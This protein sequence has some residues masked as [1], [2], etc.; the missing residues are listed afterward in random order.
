MLVATAAKVL[1]WPAVPVEI[2]MHVLRQ[3]AADHL[4]TSSQSFFMVAGSAD[5]VVTSL[6]PPSGIA[7]IA[8]TFR[9]ARSAPRIALVTSDSLILARPRGR[10]FSSDTVVSLH[11]R[12]RGAWLGVGSANRYASR[13]LPDLDIRCRKRGRDQ[14]SDCLGFVGQVGLPAAP[15]LDRLIHCRIDGDKKFDGEKL[16]GSGHGAGVYGLYFLLAIGMLPVAGPSAP[17]PYG[18]DMPR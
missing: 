3:L 16:F 8:M 10:G 4:I 2:G 17:G 9:P 6:K 13:A 7:S 1:A 14:S 15:V 12:P 18:R 5:L 11:P